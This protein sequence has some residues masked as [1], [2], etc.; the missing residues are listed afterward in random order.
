MN[1]YIMFGNL[2]YFAEQI[3]RCNIIIIEFFQ[4]SKVSFLGV[5]DAPHDYT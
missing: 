2:Q 1:F 3:Q 4:L 5:L